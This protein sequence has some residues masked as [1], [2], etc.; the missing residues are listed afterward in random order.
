MESTEQKGP[1]RS[2]CP[3]AFWEATLVTSFACNLSDPFLSVSH[4]TVFDWGLL[5]NKLLCFD[6]HWAFPPLTYMLCMFISNSVHSNL[7]SDFLLQNLHQNM[8]HFPEIKYFSSWSKDPEIAKKRRKQ[9]LESERYIHTLS[10]LLNSYLN[11]VKLHKL[12]YIL[13]MK[14]NKDRNSVQHIVW[15]KVGTQHIVVSF[16]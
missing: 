6:L 8:S 3:T 13:V 14:E 16:L 1:F 12:I 7:S 5:L 15:H 10:L 4:F 11:L 2:P 9:A